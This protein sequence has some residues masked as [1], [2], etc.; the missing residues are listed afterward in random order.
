MPYTIYP[1]TENDVTKKFVM[2]LFQRWQKNPAEFLHIKHQVSL[3][4]LEFFLLFLI[5]L[6]LFV[7]VCWLDQ[8]E[9]T[10]SFITD[11]VAMV[12]KMY[13]KTYM[14]MYTRDN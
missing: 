11:I 4:S 14:H 5:L 10:E 3:I 2:F 9:Y 12:T 6:N 13:I 1:D 7:S 8:C